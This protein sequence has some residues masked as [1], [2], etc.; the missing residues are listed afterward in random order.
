MSLKKAVKL[1]LHP[2][3][4]DGPIWVTNFTTKSLKEFYAE[5]SKLEADPSY[6]VIPVIV[7]SYGGYVNSLL[8]MRDIIKSSSKP[9]ATISL[10]FSMSCGAS[11]LAA[12]TKGYRF[13]APSSEIL[14][15]D[16]SGSMW[17]KQNDMEIQH[18]QGLRRD[19]LFW[20]ALAEDTGVS[21]EDFKKHLASIKNAD[22]YL[23]PQEALQWGVIDF[24]GM[25]RA[26]QDLPKIGLLLSKKEKSK[27]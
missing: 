6:G 2:P 26:V 18:K 27:K 11:L 13:A 14:I 5:F 22:W 21:V 20:G 3:E 24:I 4:S 8:A 10:G 15:H 16:T 12:G 17:G 9:V 1:K 7:A 23:S 19:K 25:P